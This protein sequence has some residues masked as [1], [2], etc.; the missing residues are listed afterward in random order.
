MEGCVLDPLAFFLSASGRIAPRPFWLG[1]V[2][3]YAASLISHALT[4][5]PV[6]A[7]AGLWPFVLAQA[8]LTWSWYALHAKRLRDGGVGTGGAAGAAILYG[9]AGLL[10]VLIL[11]VFMD[12]GS[13]A[14]EAAPGD[15]ASSRFL[16]FLFVLYVIGVLWG[17]ID[18]GSFWWLVAL[19]LLIA[20]L[21]I[22]VGL[23]FTLYAGT[24]PT[25]A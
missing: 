6:V 18:F 14:P 16:G 5:L 2:A 8:I 19:L 25:K 20:L 12:V 22:L 23:G 4:D 17:T 15:P 13:G 1:A 21:P 10:M 24:R 7:R 11:A 3:V 9:L